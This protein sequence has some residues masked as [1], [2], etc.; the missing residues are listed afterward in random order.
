MW[1]KTGTF[2]I[3]VSVDSNNLRARIVKS[4]RTGPVT[5]HPNCGHSRL[6][7]RVLVVGPARRHPFAEKK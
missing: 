4:I 7:R 3:S 1:F 2:V 6:R 5:S